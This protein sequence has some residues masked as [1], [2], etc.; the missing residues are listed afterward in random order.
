[1]PYCTPPIVK[2]W[3]KK[4]EFPNTNPERGETRARTGE[5]LVVDAVRDEQPRVAIAE[6]REAELEARA[7][8]AQRPEVGDGVAQPGI[9]DVEGPRDAGLPNRGIGVADGEVADVLAELPL[10]VALLPLTEQVWLVQ[11]EK[12]SHARALPDRRAEIDVARVFLGQDR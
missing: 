7:P 8:A 9:V 4:G 11:P 3:S 5:A 12:P 6:D 1:M 10:E 2:S